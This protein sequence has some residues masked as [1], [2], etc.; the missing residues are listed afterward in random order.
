MNKA[1]PKD[2]YPFLCVD[3]FLKTLVD[4]RALASALELGLIDRL[5]GGGSMAKI[6]LAAG[7]E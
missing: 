4:A 5:W 6:T 7:L 2:Q 1:A 3:D